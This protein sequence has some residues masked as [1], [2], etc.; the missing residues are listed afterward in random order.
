MKGLVWHLHVDLTIYLYFMKLHIS[1]DATET[2]LLRAM[3][4]IL[5]V[6]KLRYGGAV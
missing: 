1:F 6:M 5:R 4:V 3:R 2:A